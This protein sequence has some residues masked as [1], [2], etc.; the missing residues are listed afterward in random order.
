MYTPLILAA[1]HGRLKIVRKLLQHQVSVDAID[2]NSESALIHAIKKGRIHITRLLLAHYSINGHDE[3]FDRALMCAATCGQTRIAGILLEY[4]ASCHTVNSFGW[5]P[6]H[7]SAMY[8]HASL[9]ELLII[10][11]AD[12]NAVTRNGKTVLQLA[13]D[14]ALLKRGKD[15]DRLIKIIQDR[16]LTNTSGRKYPLQS[17][18]NM[19]I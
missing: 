14:A 15:P 4:G 19:S 3:L 12:I 9:V 6:L 5:T 17:D 7:C 10:S 13:H 11:G 8:G 2:N 1:H 18:S 16:L